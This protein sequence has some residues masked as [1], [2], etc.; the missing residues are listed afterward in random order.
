MSLFCGWLIHLFDTNN[1]SVIRQKGESQY[2]CFKKTKHAKF[3]EKQTFLTLWYV[4]CFSWNTCFQIRPF[5]LLP[6][7]CKK[8]CVTSCAVSQKT[9]KTHNIISVPLPLQTVR[10]LNSSSAHDFWYV[11]LIFFINIEMQC[12]RH[13]HLANPKICSA[14]L[15]CLI[16][17]YWSWFSVSLNGN[18]SQLLVTNKFVITLK[19]NATKII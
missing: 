4:L 3:S 1:S 2:G 18:L 19:V 9:W 11:L 10:L 7:N 6:T 8:L 13:Y 17:I 16:K 5:A 12:Y 15:R 14:Y